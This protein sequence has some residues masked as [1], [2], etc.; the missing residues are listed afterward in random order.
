MIKD[1]NFVKLVGNV[2]YSILSVLECDFMFFSI[3]SLRIH[4]FHEI[5]NQIIQNTL[6]NFYFQPFLFF[7]FNREFLGTNFF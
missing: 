5:L 7:K 1:G 4:Y 2:E 3:F 6:E